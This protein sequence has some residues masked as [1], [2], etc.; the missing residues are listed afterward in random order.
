M[1][2]S[3]HFAILPRGGILDDLRHPSLWR[4]VQNGPHPLRVLD[5]I[6][7]ADYAQT[8]LVEAR[9]V[10]ASETG[11]SIS[12]TKK[13]DVDARNQVLPET[14]SHRIVFAWRGYVIE[15]KATGLLYQGGIV[16]S[17]LGTAINIMHSLSPKRAVA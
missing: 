17:D 1:A 11:A 14:K 9:V 2:W 10:G 16:Y 15:T 6:T 7:V 4:D 8:W 5:R 13:H 3:E 12:I